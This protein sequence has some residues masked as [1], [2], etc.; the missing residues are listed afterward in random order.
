MVISGATK[1]QLLPLQSHSPSLMINL[2][3]KMRNLY[4]KI[5]GQNRI[6]VMHD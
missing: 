4:P 2:M 3:R 1:I 6:I 5:F